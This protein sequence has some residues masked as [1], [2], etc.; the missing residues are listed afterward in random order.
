MAEEA[1]EFHYQKLADEIERKVLAGG[2]R[3]GDKLPSLRSLHAQTGLSLTTVYRAYQELENRGVAEPKEKSGF[4]VTSRIQDILPPPGF[5][6][7]DPQP[8]QVRVNMLVDAVMAALSDTSILHMGV[9]V[10]APELLPLKQLAASARHAAD[11]YKKERGVGYG[12]PD[13][14]PELRRQIAKR[15]LGFGDSVDMDEI[16]ITSGCM[17]AIQL[18][19]KA[20]ANPGDTILVESPTFTCYLQLIED[21]QMLA[22]EAPTS[23]EFGLDFPSLEKA[24]AEHD[25]KAC[26]LNPSF[27][28]PLGFEMSEEARRRVVE[29]MGEKAIPIIEDDIY[30]ELYFGESRPRP[31]KSFD[32]KGLVLY[33]SSFS[34]SL[35]PDPRVGWTMPGKFI[36]R[37]R[38]LKF[39]TRIAPSKL[40]QVTIAHYLEGGSYDRHLRKLRSALKNQMLNTALAIARHFPAGTRVSAPRGGLI[41]WVQMDAR[42]DGMRVFYEARGQKIFVLPGIISSTAERYAN[43]IRV[44]CANLWS[45]RIETGICT[46]G[47]IA[48]RQ[49]RAQSRPGS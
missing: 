12:P 24:V 40:N 7:H 17:D 39:N 34:K 29:F 45:E 20:V 35:A 15:A 41:L 36:D 9:S 1:A 26:I 21:M 6:R 11:I 13:G 22:L 2:Y 18:C 16:I 48:A 19:L 25:V 44:S 43:C 5:E 27:Q 14:T 46:L 23:P 8:R 28:N 10:P 32:R 42:V 49:I 31:L 3:A 37:V 30:G 38:R 4:F 33:C 47:Q